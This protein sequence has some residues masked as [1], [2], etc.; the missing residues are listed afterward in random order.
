MYQ[1]HHWAHR[2]KCM[3][4]IQ[5]RKVL[6]PRE[7]PP[8]LPL[9]PRVP[10]V[11]VFTRSNVEQSSNGGRASARLSRILC[12]REKRTC[13]TLG[14]ATSTQPA[15]ICDTDA[16]PND[17]RQIVH[18]PLWYPNTRAMYRNRPRRRVN[19]HTRPVV[20][21]VSSQRDSRWHAHIWA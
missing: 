12:L 4:S 14:S 1:D 2:R 11:M 9:A 7:A 8:N 17:S 10:T 5:Y 18:G 21:R 3:R 13:V 6:R 16:P 15:F 20:P 19:N